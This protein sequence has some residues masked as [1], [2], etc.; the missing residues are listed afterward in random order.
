MA[1]YN[2]V[3]G[4]F[5]VPPAEAT[6]SRIILT[7]SGALAWPSNF[8]GE[9]A[10]QY[11]ATSIV[12]LSA[13]SAGMQL[14]LP[15]ANEA[16]VGQDILIRNVGVSAVEVFDAGGGPLT[17]VDSGASKYFYI[18]NNST[19]AGE[20]SVFTYGTGTSGADASLLSGEGLSVSGNKLQ[21]SAEYRALDSDYG[22]TPEDRG[23]LLNATIGTITVTTPDATA[24]S[25][26]FYCFLKNSSFG[27]VFLAGFG[28]QTVDGSAGKTLSPGDSL[29]LIK[30][31][32]NWVT[33]GFGQSVQFTFTELVI[34]SA[35]GS[36][37]LTS[38]DVAVE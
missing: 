37:T 23:L 18:V 10:D 3:F 32:S 30:A 8:S 20:W 33:V 24:V 25:D 12:E 28:A 34:N 7:S 36:A 16:S 4:T 21:V 17:V 11:L 26:G 5:T 38:T 22:I 13:D 29:V 19:S 31:D 1:N 14:L 15:P 9:V 27:S 35:A 2:D 6:Y